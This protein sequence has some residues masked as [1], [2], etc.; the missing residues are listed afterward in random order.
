MKEKASAINSTYI[1]DGA[2]LKLTP[3]EILAGCLSD[4]VRKEVS[5][6]PAGQIVDETKDPSPSAD[7]LV[8]GREEEY[9]R[10]IETSTVVRKCPMAF[11]GPY[12]KS[13]AAQAILDTIWAKGHF[14]LRDLQLS[15]R[16]QWDPAPLGNM[17]AFYASVEAA[18]D[19]IDGLGICLS[20]YTY[21]EKTGSCDV[22]FKVESVQ[23]DEGR[24]DDEP[25]TI[26][27][28][29][30]GSKNPS[31]GKK[32]AV[33]SAMVAD[34]ESWLIFIPF[35]TC[36]FRLGGSRLCQVQGSSGDT[37][38]EIG[39][40]D[41]FIDCHEVVREFV[42]DRVVL[43]GATVGEGGL[44]AAIKSMCTEKCGATMDVVGIKNAYGESRSNRVLFSEIPGVII[45]IKD[46]DYDYVDAELLLQD[47][48]YY[49]LGHPV[50]G[51]G[52]IKV[53]TGGASALTQILQSLM[54]SQASEGE[55]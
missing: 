27:E 23:K 52:R 51:S 49:P 20:G 43:S 3:A 19:Y 12:T 6:V 26:P 31:I 53:K 34:P 40:A 47:I 21:S 50:P 54:N 17:A 30:F 25:A 5:D 45:Q 14:S 16:W 37:F 10:S 8:E 38:P 33:P 9:L 13:M 35:D 4:G 48:A 55:D 41:Y 42:E 46:I 24:D 7:T 11:S 29:P 44:L 32:R 36:D 28:S 15:V 2:S 39:D 1:I 22:R 18:A